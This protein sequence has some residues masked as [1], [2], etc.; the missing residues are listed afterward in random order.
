MEFS[1]QHIAHGAI[2]NFIKTGIHH[3]SKVEM[4]GQGG[5]GLQGALVGAD[6]N[7]RN[8]FIRKLGD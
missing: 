6:V 4:P 8:R 3:G 2:I 5:A 7:G 1:I